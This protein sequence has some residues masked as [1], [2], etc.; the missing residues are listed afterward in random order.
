[1]LS[2]HPELRPS[3][4]IYQAGRYAKKGH[5]AGVKMNDVMRNMDESKKRNQLMEQLGAKQQ[6]VRDKE[7]V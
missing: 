6:S 5:A 2:T 7:R 4:W 1:M 3:A